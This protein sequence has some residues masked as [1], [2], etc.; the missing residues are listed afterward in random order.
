MTTKSFTRKHGNDY[1][2]LVRLST[3]L[4]MNFILFNSFNSDKSF[5]VLHMNIHSVQLHIEEFRIILKILDFQFDFIC[6][7]ES[8]IQKGFEPKTDIN[9]DGYQPPFGVP[10]EATKGGVLLYAKIGINAIP[11]NDLD[12]IMYKP[13][14]LESVFVEVIDSKDKNSIV[15]VI[16]RHPCMDENIFNEDYI[17]V[18]KEKNASDNKKYYIWHNDDQLSYACH[19]S[20]YKN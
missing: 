4:L 16:Y 18:F 7:S 1:I 12:N 14:E 8:K 15:G 9:I 20:T 5:S 2:I 6:L 13:K 17:K 10:T 11:R 3:I 19:C